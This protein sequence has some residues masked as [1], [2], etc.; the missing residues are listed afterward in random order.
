M[1]AAIF[2]G[3]AARFGEPTRRRLAPAVR[4]AALWQSSF[5][6]CRG[7]H[8]AKPFDRE[9]LT[10]GRNKERTLIVIGDLEDTIEHVNGS[11]MVS[12]AAVPSSGWTG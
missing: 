6:N 7:D 12:F 1:I 10:V 3:R 4:F 8:I 5:V 2:A 9:R 11:E